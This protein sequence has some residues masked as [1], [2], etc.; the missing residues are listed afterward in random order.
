LREMKR[1]GLQPGVTIILE[2]GARGRSLAVRLG[3]GSE[4]LRLSQTLAAGISVTA[5]SVEDQ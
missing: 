5:G 2:A 1:L 3:N 4:E